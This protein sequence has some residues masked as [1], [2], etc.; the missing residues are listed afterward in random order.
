VFASS[1]SLLIR[2]I[3]AALRQGFHLTTCPNL[4]SHLCPQATAGYFRL[5]AA[6]HERSGRIAAPEYFGLPIAAPWVTRIVAKGGTILDSRRRHR[7]ILDGRI[8]PAAWL[9]EA[10]RPPC[11]AQTSV[12][13]R[14]AAHRQ[15]TA[16]SR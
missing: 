1:F 2:G 10:W 12:A 3:I 8:P 16:A 15:H 14:R 4:A 6:A 5:V 11:S 7:D 13:V 9:H